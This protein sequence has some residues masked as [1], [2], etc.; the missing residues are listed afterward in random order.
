MIFVQ[1]ELMT[2]FFL[3]LLHLVFAQDQYTAY[4]TKSLKE[5]KNLQTTYNKKI[6][7]H[8]GNDF[9]ALIFAT[10]LWTITQGLFFKWKF[11]LFKLQNYMLTTLE[12]VT[13]IYLS[14]I[15]VL[16]NYSTSRLDMDNLVLKLNFY[17]I[18]WEVH[19]TLIHSQFTIH[20]LT[21]GTF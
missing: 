8:L 19:I 17:T 21:Y 13:K 3:T 20:N 2:K 4:I 16:K 11:R 6:V 10:L 18:F 7:T 5:T 9:L 1:W 12:T 15:H 14:F